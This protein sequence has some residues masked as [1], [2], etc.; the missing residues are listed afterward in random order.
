MKASK[1]MIGLLFAVAFPV[2]AAVQQS[3]SDIG[4]G[5]VSGGLGSGPGSGI[6]DVEIFIETHKRY[7]RTLHENGHDESFCTVANL[8]ADRCG[9]QFSDIDGLKLKKKS[10]QSY[11]GKHPAGSTAYKIQGSLNSETGTKWEWPREADLVSPSQ[12]WAYRDTKLLTLYFDDVQWNGSKIAS[13]VRVKWTESDPGR[14][15]DDSEWAYFNAGD[16]LTK[17]LQGPVG[18]REILPASNDYFWRLDSDGGVFGQ[19]T[20]DVYYHVSCSLYGA[21]TPPPPS[22]DP[23]QCNLQCGGGQCSSGQCVCF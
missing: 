23:Q 2:A 18:H 1:W 9:P 8:P 14:V 4:I 22:C 3:D 13:K 16:M 20:I 10:V 12:R 7:G 19:Y 5:Y 21:G 6:Y 15:D 17:C 11:S